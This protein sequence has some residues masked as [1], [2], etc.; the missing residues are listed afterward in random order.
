MSDRRCGIIRDR[1]DISQRPSVVELRERIGDLEI[2]TIIGQNHQ[3]AIVTN[4][5]CKLLRF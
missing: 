1:I 2:D 4:L 3:G 5:S